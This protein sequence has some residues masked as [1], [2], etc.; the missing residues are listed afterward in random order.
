M[1]NIKCNGDIE[2]SKLKAQTVET[3][4]IDIDGA[5]SAL[6]NIGNGFE[7]SDS[8]NVG[9]ELGRRDGTPGTPYIDFHTD[10]NATDFNARLLAENNNIKITADGLY[11]NNKQVICS[12]GE[13]FS[14]NGYAKLSNGLILQ[15]MSITWNQSTTIEYTLPI[16]FPH[17]ILG[18]FRGVVS[19]STNS[20]TQYR[21]AAVS[22][23]LPTGNQ[24]FNM[25][26]PQVSGANNYIL[27]IGY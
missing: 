24:K 10:G 6:K 15:W 20:G 19:G 8:T 13:S 12:N 1:A 4:K 27:A 2:T 18:L 9:I 26:M 17:A 5:F 3:T 16:Q 14:A 21:S 22:N 25:T 23:D 7:I 11:V